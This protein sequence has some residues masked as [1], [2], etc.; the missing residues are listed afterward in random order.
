M[1]NPRSKFKIKIEQQIIILLQ[2]LFLYLTRVICFLF[3]EQIHKHSGESKCIRIT[4]LVYEK[5]YTGISARTVNF[6]RV[7][8]V[9]IIYLFFANVQ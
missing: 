4:N 8:R 1:G 2:V 9:V 5:Q 7:L 3:C 6:S